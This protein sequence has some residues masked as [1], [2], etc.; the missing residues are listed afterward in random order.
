MEKLELFNV[1]KNY[2]GFKALSDV[3]LKLL[4]GEVHAIM[5]ENGAGKT[6]L[7]KVLAGVLKADK[8]KIKVD[9]CKTIRE[10]NGIACSSRNFFLSTKESFIASQ[11]YKII[12]R[13]PTNLQH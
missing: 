7:I 12:Y 11:I 3:S 10:K 9:G 2:S 13:I 1:S 4:S 8:I 5:G 6:T